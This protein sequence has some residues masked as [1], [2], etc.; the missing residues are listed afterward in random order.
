[1]KK[2]SFLIAVLLLLLVQN[3]VFAQETLGSSDS[4]NSLPQLQSGIPDPAVI[5]GTIGTLYQKDYPYYDKLYD[6]Y[7]YPRPEPAEAFIQPYTVTA[8][9]AGYI[10]V[11]EVIDG[12]SVLRIRPIGNDSIAALLFYDYQGYML[13]MVPENMV[14]AADSR[15]E[16]T[17]DGP[18]LVQL[19]AEAIQNEDY[20]AAVRY[21]IRA[22]EI[23]ISAADEPAG[24][25]PTETPRPSGP[26]T[27]VVQEGDNCWSIAVDKFGVNFELFMQVN[28]MVSCDIGIGDE[29]IIPGADQQMATPTPI[30]LDQYTAGQIIDYVVQMNDSYND[31]ASKFNTTLQSIQG[32]NNVNAY[33]G[34]PQ[35]G[36]VLKIEVNLVTPTPTIEPTATIEPGTIQP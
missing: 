18:Q 24:P 32:L 19:G 28:N 36:Q 9:N 29:V 20:Q 4:L 34:F 16:D 8:G 17:A 27:Y 7:L 14:L 22:A 2:Y 25:E 1:M 26:S 23:Y 6:T 10:T 5:L 33:T 13:L 31:I 30:P 12:Y 3:S 11:P 21:L 35:Y 15:T